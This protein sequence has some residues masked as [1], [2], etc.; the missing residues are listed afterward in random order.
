MPQALPANFTI[1]APVKPEHEFLL[2]DE[3]LLFI[4]HLHHHFEK[5]RQEL[6]Q[7]RIKRQARID[8]G[9]MPDFL[10]ETYHIR[11]GDWQIAP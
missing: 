3:A 11:A 1:T 8:Q 7:A 4:A 10:P 5:R 2:S 9:E 6:L